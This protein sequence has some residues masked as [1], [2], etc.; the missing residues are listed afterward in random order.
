MGQVIRFPQQA[1][2]HAHERRDAAFNVACAMTYV[3][4]FFLAGPM[5]AMFA[6]A[7]VVTAQ[8]VAAVVSI[9]LLAIVWKLTVA[10]YAR[11]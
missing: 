7:F 3:L 9:A 10:A 1:E 8:P 4:G 2:T 5:L 6:I 11:L